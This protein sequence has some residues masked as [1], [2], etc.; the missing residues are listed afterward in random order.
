MQM[1]HL[2]LLELSCDGHIPAR[3]RDALRALDREEAGRR[4]RTVARTRTNVVRLTEKGQVECLAEAMVRLEAR[5]SAVTR[6]DLMRHGFTSGQLDAYG[7]RA[8]ARA[9]EIKAARE[10]RR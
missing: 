3:V 10:Q 1:G 2:N 8:A 4:P 9:D 5:G 7:D 6:R